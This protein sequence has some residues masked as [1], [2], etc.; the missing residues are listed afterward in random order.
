M[1]LTRASEY[2]LLSL[3]KIEQSDVPVGAQQLALEL[4]LPKSFLAKILQNLAKSEILESKRG[5]NGGFIL[6]KDANNIS[7]YS[8][9]LAAE[10]KAP[11]IF[12]CTQYS[13]SCPNGSIGACAISP[14]LAKFQSKIDSFLYDLTLGDILK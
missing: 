2:A 5:V 3:S 1:L 14:F 11:A 8:V 6:T 12:D 9:I 10:G 7:I 4:G 13:E